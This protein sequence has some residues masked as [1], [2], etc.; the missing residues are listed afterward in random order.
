ME[1]ILI[2][3]LIL[4]TGLLSMAATSLASARTASLEYLAKQGNR[5]VQTALN[6]AQQP[7]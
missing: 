6:L 2:L 7:S 4:L 3:G 5:R 1:I